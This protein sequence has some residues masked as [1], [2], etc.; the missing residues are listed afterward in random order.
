[1]YDIIG[2]LGR[3]LTIVGFAASVVSIFAYFRSVHDDS[4]TGMAR[5]AFHVTVTTVILASAALLILILKHQFQ[6]HYVWA[7]SSRS[8]PFGFLASTF[9]A[10]QEGSFLLWTLMLAVIG[11]ILMAYAQRKGDEP[12]VM[13]VYGTI[14]SFMVLLVVM[15]NPFAHIDAD[16]IPAD[17]KGL[18]PLLQNFWMQIHPPILF[19]GFA[20]MAP[21]FAL[22]IAALIRREYQRWVVSALPWL[23]AGAGVL[24][25]GIALGG[26]WAYETLGW[27]GWWGWD[28]VENS[29]LIPWV[30]GVAAVHTLL[31]QRKTQGLI[32]TN[33]VLV[34]LGFVLVIY[35]TFLTRSGVLGDASV[36][37][38]AD[39]GRFVFTLLVL[40]MFVFTDF[41]LAMLFARFTRY[42]ESL[43]ERF[44]GWRLIGVLYAV[45]IVPSIPLFARIGGDVVPVLQEAMTGGSTITTI[46]LYPLLGLAHMLNVLSFLWIPALIVKL[47]LIVYIFTGRVHSA[48]NFESFQLLSR[49]TMLAIGSAVLGLFALIVLIGT[50]LPIIPGFIIDAINSLLAAVGSATRLGN[51]VEPAFYDSMGLPIA[52]MMAMLTGFTLLFL[53]RDNVAG[54]ILRK[55]ADGLAVALVF[56]VVLVFAGPVRSP[57]MLTLAFFSCF[58]LYTNAKYAL[59]IMRGNWRFIGAQISHIGL[60]LML[61]GIIG[62]GFYNRSTV[63][64]LPLNTPVSAEGYQF[65]F[66]GFEPQPDGRD[67]FLV[68]IA[69]PDGTEIGVVPTVMYMSNYGGQQQIMRNP[70]IERFLTH[71]IYVEPQALE[72]SDTRGSTSIVLKEHE[73]AEFEGRRITFTG[74]TMDGGEGAGAFRI[75]GRF[76]VQSTDGPAEELVTMQITG[77]DGETIIADTTA[78]GDLVIA[79]SGVD[80]NQ[81]DMANSRIQIRVSNPANAVPG[82]E[83]R[84]MLVAQVSIKPF[85]LLVWIGILLITAGFTMAALRRRAEDVTASVTSGD[86][87]EFPPSADES[88]ADSQRPEEQMQASGAPRSDRGTE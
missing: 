64:E 68:T 65:T 66:S 23:V 57:G 19:L 82:E 58:S 62:S 86:G 34:I 44:S 47:G 85:I 53:W 60:A 31:T 4:Y 70:A 9:Y 36:H 59:R 50:S 54:T 79:F 72:T 20:A 21:P 39:P 15:K 51:T 10:G 87:G 24:G 48:K 56:T 8:L 12:E 63:L 16:T 41:G 52:I 73:S 55:A 22:A 84:E 46:L 11:I 80:V 43:W 25:L 76:D 7:Y 2:L 69:K 28:P 77:P 42:G 3:V 29:S 67:H 78:A 61:L 27:G 17:G 1:M 13:A 38:F 37:A 49:E 75:G 32:V 81:N 45:M 40:F 5:T 88:D 33:F 14:L 30:V 71:D 83:P 6:F 18:N 26:F 74:F 35:S